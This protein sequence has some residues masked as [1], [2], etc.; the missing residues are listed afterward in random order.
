MEDKVIRIIDSIQ[1]AIDEIASSHQKGIFPDDVRNS[2]ENRI[3]IMIDDFVLNQEEYEDIYQA[4][5]LLH[6]V[7]IRMAASQ[8]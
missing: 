6:N 7:T 1:A 4:L 8:N 2:L 5:F 3:N